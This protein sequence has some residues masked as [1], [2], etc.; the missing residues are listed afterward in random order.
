MGEDDVVLVQQLGDNV[1]MSDLEKTAAQIE[2]TLRVNGESTVVVGIG[3]VATHLRDLRSP[4]RKRRWRSRSASLRH[5][6]VHH[7]L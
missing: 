7:Q 3:T 2:E 1:E 4:I 5:R 6:E